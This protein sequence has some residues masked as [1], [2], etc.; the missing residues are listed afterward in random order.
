MQGHVDSIEHTYE[1]VTGEKLSVIFSPEG[2][3]SK[4]EMAGYDVTQHLRYLRESDHATALMFLG[5]RKNVSKKER[6]V[7]KELQRRLRKAE[8]EIHVVDVEETGDGMFEISLSSNELV[9]SPHRVVHYKCIMDGRTFRAVRVLRM[10]N[11]P[12]AIQLN[13]YLRFG[14]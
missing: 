14:G 5:F 8:Q 9:S 7:A 12:F 4:A 10:Y 13:G 2:V 1:A 11:C 6:Q 3:L